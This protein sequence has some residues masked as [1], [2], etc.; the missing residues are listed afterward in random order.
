M[1]YMPPSGFNYME[2]GMMFST[3]QGYPFQ[4]FRMP[5]PNQLNILQQVNFPNTGY[6]VGYKPKYSKRGGYRGGYNK[7]NHQRKNNM[8]KQNQ[9]S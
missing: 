7:N 5:F 4:M 2:Q 8:N 9:N 3:F 6:K 1:E